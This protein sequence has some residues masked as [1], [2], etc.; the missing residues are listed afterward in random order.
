VC[1]GRLRAGAAV[2]HVLEFIRSNGARRVLF[3]MVLMAPAA[4][5]LLVVLAGVVSGSVVT[6]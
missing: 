3:A 1:R 2:E 4:S 5:R 6:A